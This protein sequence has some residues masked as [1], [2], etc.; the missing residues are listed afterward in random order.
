MLDGDVPGVRILPGVPHGNEAA[1]M[2]EQESL[3]AGLRQAL[4]GHRA[5]LDAAFA[6]IP[7]SKENENLRVALEMARDELKAIANARRAEVTRIGDIVAHLDYALQGGA[8]S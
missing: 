8:G 3:I 5:A 4:E 7:G 6:Y 2:S 1:L